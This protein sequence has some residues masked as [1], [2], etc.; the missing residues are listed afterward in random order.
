MRSIPEENWLYQDENG[1]VTDYYGNVLVELGHAMVSSNMYVYAELK[2]P[3]WYHRLLFNPRKIELEECYKLRYVTEGM[4]AYMVL[5]RI[6]TLSDAI[7]VYNPKKGY[8]Y[9]IGYK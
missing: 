6:H 4:H 9:N 2:N 8:E 7:R 3:K 1:V 5:D